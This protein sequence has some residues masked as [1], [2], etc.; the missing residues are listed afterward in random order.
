MMN[1]SVN[2]EDITLLSMCTPNNIAIKH[3]RVKLTELNGE[4][5][6][7]PNKF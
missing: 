4:I 2:Q 7:S 1:E 3:M 6:K 5:D